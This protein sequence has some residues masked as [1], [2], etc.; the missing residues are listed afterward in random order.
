[1][2]NQ[3]RTQ[4]LNQNHSVTFIYQTKCEH[5]NFEIGNGKK[6]IALGEWG[7]V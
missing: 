5:Q 2:V 1:M 7:G 3:K 4:M 6:Q